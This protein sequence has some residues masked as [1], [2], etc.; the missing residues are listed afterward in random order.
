MKVRRQHRFKR[1]FASPAAMHLIEQIARAVVTGNAPD[2]AR[3][4][5]RLSNRHVGEVVKAALR[6][7]G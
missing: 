2:I 6:A 3:K 1:Q 7:K 5:Q 4:L